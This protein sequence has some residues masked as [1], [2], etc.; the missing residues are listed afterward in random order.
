M[1]SSLSILDRPSKP[2][3]L[4]ADGTR[5]RPMEAVSVNPIGV[6]IRS[7]R[8]QRHRYRRHLWSQLYSA[9]EED[10]PAVADDLASFSLSPTVRAAPLLASGHRFISFGEG[11]KYGSFFSSL[12]ELASTRLRSHVLIVACRRRLALY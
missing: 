2:E 1:A 12:V 4:V 6:G 3:I 5:I 10:F 8:R 9:T 7:G 11:G